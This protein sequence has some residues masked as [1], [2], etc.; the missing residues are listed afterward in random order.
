V[1]GNN[2]K[3][4]VRTTCRNINIQMLNLY[5]GEAHC[6]IYTDTNADALQK[7]YASLRCSD[8]VEDVSKLYEDAYNELYSLGNHIDISSSIGNAV[9][10]KLSN[11]E[12]DMVKNLR[13]FATLFRP[14]WKAIQKHQQKGI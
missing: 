14:C 12:A 2:F 3:Q 13:S 5:G 11:N 1:D 4:H 6:T 8:W 7:A 9:V 10:A